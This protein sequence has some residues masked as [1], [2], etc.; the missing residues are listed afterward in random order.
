MQKIYIR[1]NGPVKN[2]EMEVEKFNLLIV[3]VSLQVNELYTTLY[4]I[5]LDKE[6]DLKHGKKQRAG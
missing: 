3:D 1:N 2:F 6:Q 4:G 5:E